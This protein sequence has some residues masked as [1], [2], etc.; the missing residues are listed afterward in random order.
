MNETTKEEPGR[1]VELRLWGEVGVFLDGQRVSPKTDKEQR[2]LACLLL[3][4]GNK[5]D[6]KTVTKWVWGEHPPPSASDDLSKYMTALRKTLAKVEL[7]KALVIEPGTCQLAV[8]EDLVDVHRFQRLVDESRS[9]KLWEEARLLD[10]ALRVSEGIP[11]AGLGGQSAENHRVGLREARFAAHLRSLRLGVELGRHGAQIPELARLFDAS[12]DH[13]VITCLTMRAYHLAGRK[14]DALATHKRHVDHRKENGLD[15]AKAVQ[16]MHMSILNDDDSLRPQVD[17]GEQPPPTDPTPA[18]D[19]HLILV[20]RP[21]NDDPE[22]LRPLLDVAFDRPDL[23]VRCDD[24]R[25]VC[26]VPADVQHAT[27][28]G[29]WL[30]RL[31]HRLDQRVVAG[32]ATGDE[33]HADELAD[34]EFARRVLDTARTKNLVVAVSHDLYKSASEHSDAT[35]YRKDESVDDGWVRVPGYST[36]PK[37]AAE[38]PK[39]RHQPP[40]RPRGNSTMVFNERSRIG[41][42]IIGDTFHYGGA[43]SDD[44]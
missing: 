28:I 8:P 38:R 15:P 35:A 1:L 42:Q 33:W 36:A 23:E 40:A 12:R 39:R 31:A 13:A 37:P 2:L 30:D 11:L 25:L 21:E 41:R 5:A 7:D 22:S 10:Q 14:Q 26:V 29:P 34:S 32:V 9:A 4:K 6:R 24:D 18:V 3:F 43:A 20:L 17:R 19:T 16:D 44:R 27:V